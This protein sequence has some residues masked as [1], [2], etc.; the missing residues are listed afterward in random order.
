[1][2]IAALA[3]LLLGTPAFRLPASGDFTRPSHYALEF[4]VDPRQPDFRGRET[5]DLVVEGKP[6]VI[7]L[8]AVE[9]AITEAS[10]AQ[11]GKTQPL[12]VT[13][14]PDTETIELRPATPL[15]AGAAQLGLRFGAPLRNDLRG[16]YVAKSKNGEAYA[17]TQFEATDARRAFPCYDEPAFKATYS[18][19]AVVPDG[20]L[21][22]SNGNETNAQG[23]DLQAP[24]GLHPVFFA[25]TPPISSYLVALAVGKFAALEADVSASKHHT[26]LRVIAPAGDEKLGKFAL[27]M[28]VK[29]L[30][31]YE[32]YFGI[33]YPFAKLDMV[34][35]PD[36]DAG[37]MEN[38]G[39]IFYRDTALLLDEKSA[40][41]QAQK[42]VGVVVVHEMAHQWFG[43][44]VTMAWWD[45]LWLNEAFASLMEGIALEALRPDWEPWNQ[46]QLDTQDVMVTDSLSATHPIHVAV[47]TAEE[48]NALFDDITYN[49][50]SAVLHMFQRTLTPKL[51]QVGVQDYLGSHAFANAGEADLWQALSAATGKDVAKLAASWFDQ[52]GYPL[53]YAARDSGPSKTAPARLLLSQSPFRVGGKAPEGEVAHWQ[54]PVCLKYPRGRMLSEQCTL[55]GEVT[56]GVQL[57]GAPAW[58]DANADFGGFYR[59]DYDALGW[60][61]LTAA[62]ERGSA[63]GPNAAERM[64][65][66]SDADWLVQADRAPLRQLL[67]LEGQLGKERDFS[68]WRTALAQLEAIEQ[69]LATPRTL[70]RYRAFLAK[71]LR[72][73][74]DELG[75][76]AAPRESPSRRSL[77]AGVLRGLAALTDDPRTVASARAHL[78]D[79]EKDPRSLDQTLLP[80]VLESAAAHG[81]DAALWEHFAR[82]MAA[83]ESPEL[84]DRYR[85]ALADFRDP[86]LVQKTLQLTLGGGL[87]K[88]DV[89]SELGALLEN[90][91]A[92]TQAFQFLMAHWGELKERFT[93]LAAAWTILP[94]LGSFCSAADRDTLKAFFADP[95]HHVDGGDRAMALA[96]ERIDLCVHFQA[97]HAT[98]LSEWLAKRGRRAAP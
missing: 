59:V 44:L 78:S 1:M 34:A 73:A 18:I 86:A 69:T 2:P 3:A 41:V 27:D 53:I 58:I 76:T 47:S 95:A 16:L 75:W 25:Q 74:A 94:A 62:F 68:V 96:L 38:A 65:L 22:I 46:V 87:R 67:D 84:R 7:V 83:A 35:I 5:I 88:Q 6:Q 20:M 30:P 79:F 51:W 48:A 97:N 8:H 37:G 32:D 12:Q 70:P 80:L 42:R 24:V 14:H 77:R 55:L 92:R 54:V 40:S 11:G 93:G 26:H 90:P 23:A 81:G 56:G 60:K 52:S 82:Q 64:A 91:A 63:E 89:A 57:E 4:T 10:V 28:A 17:V 49:K 45:D 13:V 39:A 71:L 85:R 98:E 36:F 29:A 50:G 31:F 21:A 33:P 19:T 66:L 72:P 15:G 9:L 43:D 61:A